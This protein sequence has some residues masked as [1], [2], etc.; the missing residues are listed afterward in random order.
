[1]TNNVVTRNI[2][3]ADIRGLSLAKRALEVMVAGGF[4]LL[5]HGPP[6]VGKTM[7]ARRAAGLFPPLS[8][9]AALEVA[10]IHSGLGRSSESIADHV[11]FRAPHYTVA[12]AGLLGGWLA[13][14]P[15]PRRGEVLL[16][17]R[18]LLFLDELPEFSR[19]C[20]DGVRSVLSDKNVRIVR[21]VETVFP[22]DFQ[23]LAAMNACP[24]G[25]YGYDGWQA[26]GAGYPEHRCVCPIEA[27]RR[28]QQRI[29]PLADSFELAVPVAQL[30]TVEVGPC[31]ERSESIRQRIVK[32][33]EIARQRA[34]GQTVDIFGGYAAF[35]SYRFGT[36]VERRRIRRVARTIADLESADE[37]MDL[38]V[39][40]AITLRQLP[41]YVL[42]E[43]G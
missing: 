19:G 4:N 9:E 39:A 5:L 34:A 6:G 23:L 13:G 20:L 26:R 28:Y 27:V 24:C 42:T 35:T 38:H 14:S 11:P 29:A 21:S 30:P 3:M 12:T 40:E 7:L 18:G 32:A 36:E 22:A 10:E 33:Q 37:V 41:E 16:A 31:S 25:Y 17:H 2:D 43:K 8:K 15:S 1:M